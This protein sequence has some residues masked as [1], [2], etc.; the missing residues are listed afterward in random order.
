MNLR[1]LKPLVISL[2]L[3][4]GCSSPLHVMNTPVDKP[5]LS[6]AS[7]DPIVLDVPT[8][9]LV[10]S[11]AKSGQPNSVDD[12]F[13]NNPALYA[14]T[15][16]DKSKEILNAAKI[17]AFIIQLQAQLKAYQLYYETWNEPSSEIK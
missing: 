11:G 16:E 1:N 2:F 3:L 12:L 15:P 7:P 17:K 5:K 4:A 13:K 8:S 9:H 6:V 14:E 10:V